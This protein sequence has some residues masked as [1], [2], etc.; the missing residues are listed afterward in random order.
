MHSLQTTQYVSQS[1][2]VTHNHIKFPICRAAI[3]NHYYKL[4]GTLSYIN[5]RACGVAVQ[6]PHILTLSTS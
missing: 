1:T 2:T 5:L 6:L 3:F 4:L